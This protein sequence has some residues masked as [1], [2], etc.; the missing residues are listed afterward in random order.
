MS[1][2]P[3]RTAL[4]NWTKNTVREAAWGPLLVFGI[5]VMALSMF[6]TFKPFPYYDV[7]MH[8]VG[9]AVMAFFFHRASINA[10]LLGITGPYQA[11][12]HRLLVFTSTCTVAVFWEFGEFLFDSY[13]GIQTQGGLADTMAD[14]FWSTVGAVSLVVLIATFVH[15]PDLRIGCNAQR[16]KNIHDALPG[17]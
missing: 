4:L 12:M 7:P 1:M 17:D 6:N 13:F 10:S 9:G 2:R 3:D 14:L 11:I 5:H 8:F 15:S 16:V